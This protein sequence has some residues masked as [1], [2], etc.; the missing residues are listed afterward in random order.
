MSKYGMT[1]EEYEVWNKK[2]KSEPYL[3]WV[4]YCWEDH[5]VYSESSFIYCYFPSDKVAKAYFAANQIVDYYQET[6]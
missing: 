2:D 6:V 5:R 1:K 4:E 3:D